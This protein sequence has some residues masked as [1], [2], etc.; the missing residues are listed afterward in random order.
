MPNLDGYEMTKQIRCQEK[1]N[2]ES[3][4]PIVAIT[5]AAMSGDE[6]RCLSV[7][8]DAFISKPVSLKDLQAALNSWY[9]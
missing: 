2:Q 1:E 4:I 9:Q 3:R 6:E 5:G 7:G 8:I